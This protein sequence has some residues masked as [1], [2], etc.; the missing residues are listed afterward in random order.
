MH[1]HAVSQVLAVDWIKFDLPAL[2]RNF[3]GL[4]VDGLSY[5]SIY[6]L[7]AI[8]YTLVYGVLRLINFAHSEV[9]LV[10]MFAQYFTLQA[11]GFTPT[12]DTYMEGTALTIVY[13]SLAMIAAMAASGATAVIVERVAYRPLRKR[14]APPLVFL[15]TAIG[16]SLVISQAFFVLRGPNPEQPIRL[17][18]PVVE[19]TLFG[20]DI[21]NVSLII[22]IS[23]IVLMVVADSFINRT[24]FGMGI[25]AVAQDPVTARLMGVNPE[26]VI[27][28]T[29]LVG[30]ILAGAAALLYTIRIPQGILYSGGFLLGIK[31]FSAAVLGGIGNLRGAL[32]GG[33]LLGVAENWGQAIFGSG[34]RDVIAFVLLIVVLMFRP[35]GIL[36]ESLGKARV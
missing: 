22:I 6:A 23:A 20:A 8:G 5:G 25:R 36:G 19:F 11:L 32:L 3:W 28:I 29:F 16:A 7:I 26:K 34:W 2:F 14:G 10:G 15:I 21:D 24:K 9:F 12:A 13:M 18:Q 27:M 1:I 4:T 17:V 30:G 33:L 31:A 35:T